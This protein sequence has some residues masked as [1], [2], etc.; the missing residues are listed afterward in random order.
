MHRQT[1]ATG[2][3]HRAEFLPGL[4]RTRSSEA[5]RQRRATESR[6][7]G[8]GASC[9]TRRDQVRRPSARRVQLTGRLIKHLARLP[10]LSICSLRSS[11]LFPEKPAQGSERW[12]ALPPTPASLCKPRCFCLFACFVLKSPYFCFSPS[13]ANET[14]VLLFFVFL[15]SGLL[16]SRV[17]KASRF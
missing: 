16:V 1:Y 5:V 10:I 6:R 7:R 4:R 9:V 12:N 2:L 17:F 11:H 15:L 8:E 3:G 14:E 13:D